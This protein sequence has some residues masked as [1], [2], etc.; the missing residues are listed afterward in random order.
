MRNACLVFPC[1]GMDVG[2]HVALAA[3]T[4]A[5]VSNV[6]YGWPSAA[7]AALVFDVRI[8]I[9][10]TWIQ[11]ALEITNVVIGTAALVRPSPAIKTQQL[12]HNDALVYEGTPQAN[13]TLL[14]RS[15]G[16][17]LAPIYP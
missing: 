1:R 7:A 9:I 6:R 8:P 2:H 13:Y 17:L 15:N 4:C 16:L 11:A 12:K 3:A 5:L 14:Q 10:P